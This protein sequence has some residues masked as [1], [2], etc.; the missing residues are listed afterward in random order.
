M[1][2]I[3]TMQQRS[4]EWFQARLG[5]V[6]ASHFGDVMAKGRG[7]KPS[8][9]RQTYLNHVVAERISRELCRELRRRR[10]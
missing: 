1:M 2:Q 9:R 6:T 4:A 8:A 3:L 5:L 10:C 7:D